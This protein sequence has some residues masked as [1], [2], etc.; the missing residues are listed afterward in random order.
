MEEENATALQEALMASKLEQQKQKARKEEMDKQ[1]QYQKQNGVN[2]SNKKKKKVVLSL[3]A[4]HALDENKV[5]IHKKCGREIRG[6]TL[7][8]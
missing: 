6:L 4:L 3:S 5:C 1:R 8:Y 7:L 2:E